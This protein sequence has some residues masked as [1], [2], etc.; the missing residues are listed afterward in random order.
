MKEVRL[1]PHEIAEICAAF[2]EFFLPQDQLWLF[3]SRTDMTKKGGDIDLYIETAMND[4]A[5]VVKARIKFAATLDMTIGEQ[6]ID[7][8]IKFKDYEL[9]IYNI[10]RTEGV[11]LI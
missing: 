5:A 7:I 4:A 11:Q 8:V 3:G 10:A 6:K 1:T 9:P 2:R